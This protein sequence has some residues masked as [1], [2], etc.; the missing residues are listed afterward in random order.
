M[1]ME[2]RRLSVHPVAKNIQPQKRSTTTKSAR[3]VSQDNSKIVLKYYPDTHQKQ[4]PGED[5]LEG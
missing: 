5:L 2:S 4:I 1:K 3:A